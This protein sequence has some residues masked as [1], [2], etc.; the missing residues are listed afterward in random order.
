MRIAGTIIWA[1]GLPIGL[2]IAA[3]NAEMTSPSWV[4]SVG[5]YRRMRSHQR[6]VSGSG[7]QMTA[8]PPPTFSAEGVS[9]QTSNCS[10]NI[11]AE[12]AS[13]QIDRPAAQATGMCGKPNALPLAP[14]FGVNMARQI[15]QLAHESE[16][17]STYSSLDKSV[18]RHARENG[19]VC[20]YKTH[21]F[22]HSLRQAARGAVGRTPRR[23]G[24]AEGSHRL[25]I[26]WEIGTREG[27]VG[28]ATY[29]KCGA[30]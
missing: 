30:T 11:I 16:Y 4:G 18:L 6:R 15:A 23:R 29:N 5:T 22:R 12:R 3:P 10:P 27:G 9:Q 8:F 20:A 19:S 26:R 25:K 24:R 7:Q 28:G 14:A 21:V 13:R 1:F 2:M 17:T